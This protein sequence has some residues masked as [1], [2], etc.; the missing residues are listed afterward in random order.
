MEITPL[1]TK[2][3]RTF[4]EPIVCQALTLCC[5]VQ[6]MGEIGILSPIFVA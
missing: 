4:V 6:H 5:L 2:E 1:R 3:G